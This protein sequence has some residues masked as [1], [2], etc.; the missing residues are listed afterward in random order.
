M[1]RCGKSR[2]Q[3][4]DFVEEGNIFDP[5]D[6]TYYINFAL[7]AIQRELFTLL[8]VRNVKRSV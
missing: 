1:K 6:H 5:S 7:I 4:C 3:I 8:S 2:S